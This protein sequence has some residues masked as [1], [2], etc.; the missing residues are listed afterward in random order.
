M[1]ALK[2]KP[3]SPEQSLEIASI[4]L[5]LAEGYLKD[6]IEDPEFADRWEWISQFIADSRYLLWRHPRWTSKKMKKAIA[7]AL[8]KTSK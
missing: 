1:S 5:E 2:I 7:V 6:V 3:R 8:N 4:A